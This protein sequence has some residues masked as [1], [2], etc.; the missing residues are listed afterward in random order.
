LVEILE[1][2]IGISENPLTVTT[3]FLHVPLLNVIFHEND[4]RLAFSV[5]GKAMESCIE[6]LIVKLLLATKDTALKAVSSQLPCQD[7]KILIININSLSKLV[8]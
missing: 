1:K 3:Y 7:E 6:I 2:H 4:P 8:N 5:Q